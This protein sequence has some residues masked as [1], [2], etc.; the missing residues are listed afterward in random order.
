MVA[1]VDMDL[2]ADSDTQVVVGLGSTGLSCARYLARLGL[3]VQVVDS[4]AAPPGVEDL[5]QEHPDME[6]TLGEFPRDLLLRAG[7]LIVSPGVSLEEPVIVEAIAAGIPVPG[8][9]VRA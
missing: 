9:G 4:R 7:R 5:R 2:M 1:A 6:I 8:S 3:P